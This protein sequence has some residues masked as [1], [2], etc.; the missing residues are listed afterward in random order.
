LRARAPHS[1]LLEDHGSTFSLFTYLCFHLPS[2][3][4]TLSHLLLNNLVVSVSLIVHT[5]SRMRYVRFLKTP[6]M[7]EDKKTSK[8]HI[9]CLIT[10]TSDLGDSFIPYDV[11]LSAELWQESN[12]IMHRSRVQWTAGM[13]S[14][15]I[16]IPLN[17]EGYV[18][19]L[20]IRVGAEHGRKR[21]VFEELHDIE[22][23]GVMSA[24]SALL[25]SPSVRGNCVAEKMVERVICS[26]ADDEKELRIWEE[27]GESIARHLWYYLTSSGHESSY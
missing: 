7:V 23:R 24:W 6:R 9:H 13:R 26:R 17:P 14:L 11:G 2:G 8:A 16:T 27:T 1:S 25:R 10:I 20:R 5:C 15:P 4:S 12:V 19:P 18:W 21:D 3:C 22:H